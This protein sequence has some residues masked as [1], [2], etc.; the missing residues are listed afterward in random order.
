M[1]ETTGMTDT[2]VASIMSLH[3]LV[4]AIKVHYSLIARRGETENV[5]PSG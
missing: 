3:W 2:F 4:A 1:L 5:V